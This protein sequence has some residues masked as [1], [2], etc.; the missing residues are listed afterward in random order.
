M[1]RLILAGLVLAG[2]L[3]AV[4]FSAPQANA[5]IDCS[6]VRC[7]ACPA[8]TVFSPTPN[9]CCRCVPVKG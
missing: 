8:G 3:A 2:S 4:G 7:M 9:N 5:N 1:K 6:T